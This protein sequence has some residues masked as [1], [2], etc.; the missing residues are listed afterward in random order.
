[1]SAG[2]IQTTIPDLVIDVDGDG[3]NDVTISDGGD[4]GITEEQ[5]LVIVKGIVKTFEMPANKKAKL[6]QVI[7]K[8]EQELAKERKN[9]RAE[10]VRTDLV[11]LKLFKAIEQY[12]NKGLVSNTEA[13]ELRGIIQQIRA[14]GE[15]MIKLI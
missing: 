15:E 2:F 1:M 13:N 9:E 5:L 6:L 3:V 11:Y 7:R 14:F 4:A 10:E 8:I 12:V